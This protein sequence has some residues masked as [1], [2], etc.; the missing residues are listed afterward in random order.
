MLGTIEDVLG[1]FPAEVITPLL[2]GRITM[3]QSWENT[4]S[5]S[6]KIR[7][8]ANEFA[9]KARQAVG[10]VVDD[11]EMRAN[12]LAQEAKGHVQQAKGDVKEQVEKVV[13]RSRRNS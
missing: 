1:Y 11:N 5:T 12:G 9:G 10:K 6:D 7:G 3:K 2:L 8:N 13:D 4:S